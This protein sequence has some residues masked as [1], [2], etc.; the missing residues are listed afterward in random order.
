MTDHYPTPD[1]PQ[2]AGQAPDGQPQPAAPEAAQEAAAVVE[3]AA[4]VFQRMGRR[5]LHM[6]R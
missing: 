4:A 5:H 3:P 1:Q 6:R 2:D